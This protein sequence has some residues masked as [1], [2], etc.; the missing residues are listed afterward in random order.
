MKFNLSTTIALAIAF[1]Y[2][3]IATL[4][5]INAIIDVDKESVFYKIEYSSVNVFQP[6]YALGFLFGFSGGTLFVIIGQIIT[7]AICF[8][9]LKLIAF[10]MLK[11]NKTE[12]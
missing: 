5:L 9:I 7:F 11:N 6:G 12:K 3:G 8:V 2:V 10:L 1:I 4:I